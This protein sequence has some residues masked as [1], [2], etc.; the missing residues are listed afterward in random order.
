MLAQRY[1]SDY[2]RWEDW[3]P[4]DPASLAEAEDER[5]EKEKMQNEA[6]EK[7]N[8]EFC[9][10]VRPNQLSYGCSSSHVP[11]Q[12]HE[13]ASCFAEQFKEDMQQ[14]EEAQKKKDDSA[15][16]LRL[17]GNRWFK[18]KQWDKALVCYMDSL[19]VAPFKVETLTNVAQVHTVRC[20][21][22][23]LTL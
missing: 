5:L 2:S 18:A 16:S 7:A 20:T 3:T 11:R 4:D 12:S 15:S 21:V 22:P 9:G 10:Q 13:T 8:A 17:K 6:F 1:E 19:K 23:Q 14:R